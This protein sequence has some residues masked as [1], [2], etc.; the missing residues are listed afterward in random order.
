MFA[1][2]VDCWTHRCFHTSW[3]GGSTRS[4]TAREQMSWL[5]LAPD[6]PVNDFIRTVSRW[7]RFV[8]LGHLGIQGA[9]ARCPLPG[10]LR[11]PPPLEPELNFG[12]VPVGAGQPAVPPV[13]P[14]E[15]RRG[16]GREL[17]GALPALGSAVRA[18]C[19]PGAVGVNLAGDLGFPFRAVHELRRPET[20]AWG[21]VEAVPVGNRPGSGVAEPP[22]PSP[23]DSLRRHHPC[24]PANPDRMTGR[25]TL[26][27]T[28]SGPRRRD[29]THF[30]VWAPIRT[31]GGRGRGRSGVELRAGTGR[32]LSGSPP[33]DDKPSGSTADR[34]AVPRSRRRASS[35][36]GRTARRRSST[37]R[38]RVDRRATGAA[39]PPRARSSTRCTSARSRPRGRGRRPPRAAGAGRSASPPIEVMPVAEF[40]AGSAGATTGVFLFAP[41]RL[42][43][44]PDDLAPLRRRGPRLGLGVILDV[45]YNHFG[46]DGNY[47]REFAPHF[48]DRHTT[49]WGEAINFDGPDAGPVREFFVANAGYWIDEYHLDG[50]RLDA[51]QRS[52]TTRPS[53][54]SARS[55]AGREARGGGRPSSSARTSRRTRLVRRP[56]RRAGTGSTRCGTT[57]STTPRGSPDR[58]NE[59]VL[60][61][62]PGHAAGVRLGGEVGLPV[63]GAAVPVAHKRRAARRRSTSPPAPVRHLHREPRPGRQLRAAGCASTS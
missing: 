46:P 54:S 28:P 55:R 22:A 34:V 31:R 4:T 53:T 13:A 43:G 60:H 30:R 61:R 59:G 36:T 23:A 47:L 14:H 37:L 19:A 44:T 50:L 51:T 33:A 63:P 26:A 24:R 15:R 49:E 56:S 12:P 17:L 58:K 38:V 21:H 35:P 3:I 8:I 5:R 29:G 57:T 42:Y 25:T 10:G 40:P 9:V 39:C 41:T 18:P 11:G 20:A 45:V 2:F 6:H 52:S 62:L 16:V 1:D 32:L 27:A 7:S 48:T